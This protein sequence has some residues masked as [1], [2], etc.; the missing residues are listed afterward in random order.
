MSHNS[1]IDKA[2]LGLLDENLDGLMILDCGFGY[3]NW[4]FQIKAKLGYEPHIVG[5]EIH[6]PYIER[7]S[8]LGLYDKIVEANVLDIP[9]DNGYFDVIIFDQPHI[10]RPKG[11]EKSHMIN[12]YGWLNR[13]TYKQDLKKGLKELFRVLK[14]K[15]LLIFKWC[16]NRKETDIKMI[17]KLFPYPP[18]C[19]TKTGTSN[20]NHWICFLKYNVNMK[21]DSIQT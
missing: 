9:F 19:G 3:G 1:I 18:I 17:L 13:T 11:Y 14:P 6:H 20:N 10:I 12:E 2:V 21:L 4:A 8:K 5:L 7:Q 15:G 16:D